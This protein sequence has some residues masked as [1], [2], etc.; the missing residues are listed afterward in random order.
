MILRG[1]VEG[2]GAGGGHPAEDVSRHLGG[3]L[4]VLAAALPGHPTIVE[5]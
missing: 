5:T 3:A 2:R 4:C 1:S